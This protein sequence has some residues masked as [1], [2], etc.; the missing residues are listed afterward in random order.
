MPLLVGIA[1]PI[2]GEILSLLAECGNAKETVISTQESLEH[3]A[4]ELDAEDA[5]ANVYIRLQRVL[6][7]YIGGQSGFH[8]SLLRLDLTDCELIAIPRIKPR[9]RTASETLRPLLADVPTALERASGILS[10]REGR[11]IVQLLCTLINSVVGWAN[12]QEDASDVSNVR[13]SHIEVSE[14]VLALT[15]AGIM[16]RRT[17]SLP[18]KPCGPTRSS[19]CSEKNSSVLPSIVPRRETGFRGGSANDA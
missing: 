16:Q 3:L 11:G 12:M 19:P 15:H 13:V 10:S 8:K 4:H 14:G 2:A 17:A 6:Q 7:L 9:K 18:D 1:D 5:V